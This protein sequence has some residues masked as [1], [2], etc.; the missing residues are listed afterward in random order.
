MRTPLAGWT[1]AHDARRIRA[2]DVALH[3]VRYGSE[4]CEPQDSV[5]LPTAPRRLT[6]F[7]LANVGVATLA[8]L[9]F[10]KVGEDVFEH[11][12][13]SFDDGVRTWMLHHRTPGL[14]VLF[15]WITTAGSLGPMLVLTATV[16]RWLWRTRRRRAAAGAIAAPAFAVVLSNGIK[17]AFG[18]I[19]PDGAQY[20]ALRSFAFPSGH[21]TISTAVVATI[22]YVSWRERLLDGRLALAAAVVIPLLVGVSRMYLDVHWAT[23]VIGGWSLGLLVAALAATLYEWSRGDGGGGGAEPGAERRDR[24]IVK[25]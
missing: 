22:A 23:D 24:Q 21:A 3:R 18:R 13:G 1:L 9:L 19:R 4:M 7:L 10:A 16:V 11:E 8:L 2:R 6:R 15:T 14:F 20:F 12:S 5:E 25:L 17:L